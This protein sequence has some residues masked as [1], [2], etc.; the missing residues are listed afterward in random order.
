MITAFRFWQGGLGCGVFL[1]LVFGY[2]SST[3][4]WLEVCRIREKEN[5]SVILN[6]PRSLNEPAKFMYPEISVIPLDRLK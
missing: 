3:A 4:P 1:V 2:L 6:W 5:Y